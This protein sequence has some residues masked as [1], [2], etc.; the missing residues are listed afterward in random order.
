MTQKFFCVSSSF[1]CQFL[2]PLK[3]LFINNI[4]KQYFYLEHELLEIKSG[5]RLV[6]VYS[7]C[8]GDEQLTCLHANEAIEKISELFVKM[9]QITKPL[10]ILLEHQYT[11]ES[12]SK[13]GCKS[14]KGLDMD[15][16]N[17]L[18]T[19]ND[20]LDATNQMCFYIVNAQYVLERRD[21][22]DDYYKN[23]DL[24]KSL[25]KLRKEKKDLDVSSCSDSSCDSDSDYDDV[26]STRKSRHIGKWYD[27]EGK[28]FLVKSHFR[29]LD[30]PFKFF[31]RIININ[32]DLLNGDDIKKWNFADADIE[33][34]GNEGSTQTT[35]YHRYLLTFWP[36]KQEFKIITR[37]SRGFATNILRDSLDKITTKRAEFIENIKF[38]LNKLN[39]SFIKW[40]P[41]GSVNEKIC[42]MLEIL[43]E[44]ELYKLFLE[45][46]SEKK[47]EFTLD[48]IYNLWSNHKL[49]IELF[50]PLIIQRMEVYAKDEKFLKMLKELNDLEVIK[51]YIELAITQCN[52]SWSL[53]KERLDLAIE[54]YKAYPLSEH[55]MF[56]NAETTKL[57]YM[58]KHCE[59]ACL[60][61]LKDAKLASDFLKNKIVN[62]VNESEKLKESEKNCDSHD[63]VKFYYSLAETLILF[64]QENELV[65]LKDLILANLNSDTLTMLLKEISKESK[66]SFKQFNSSK[67]I[68]D[69]FIH[70]LKWLDEKMRTF[71]FELKM[72]EARVWGHSDVEVFLH[73]GD[74][75][76]MYNGSDTAR[77]YLSKT[78]AE[79]FIRTH[80]GLNHGYSVQMTAQKLPH[81]NRYL[82]KIVKTNKLYEKQLNQFKQDNDVLKT[83]VLTFVKNKYNK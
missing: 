79:Y 66:P 19:A 60:L 50:K 55:E 22:W 83:F 56:A 32:T 14:L 28:P 18:K 48:T 80:N 53:D 11:H 44:K 63:R 1:L 26:N 33:Y 74:A 43:K 81:S 62:I 23:S 12:L 65:K 21:G 45:K 47:A 76:L 13:N 7:L 25:R 39:D 24:E 4:I 75:E 2:F 20:K 35:R 46:L 49:E 41:G 57:Y 36:K 42:E 69:L 68:L 10:G 6:L 54:M 59:V 37:I 8:S 73:N 9:S 58:V 27:L 78:D 82:V 17:I 70:Q 34:T 71:Q 51:S 52:Q 3:V 5:Y 38:L 40:H 29:E 77:K 30:V 15:H 64:A 72:P 31:S 61:K 67:P 16:F